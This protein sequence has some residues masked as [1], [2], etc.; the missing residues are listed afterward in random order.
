[1]PI[2]DRICKNCNTPFAD[3][4]SNRRIFCSNRCRYLAAGLPEQR[5]LSKTEITDSCWLW[6]GGKDK[7][8]Y[9]R[10][11]YQSR[12]IRATYASLLILKNISVP[13]GLQVLHRCDNPSCVNPDHLF[14]GTQKDN[15]QD[16]L[17]KG[18]H[19]IVGNQYGRW[20]VG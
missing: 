2:Q 4:S 11:W 14:I 12:T 16:C 15:I 18:R 3:Y 1:M 13:K 6:I 5:F 9:G 10:F 17:A 7:D 19:P 20:M 8:G